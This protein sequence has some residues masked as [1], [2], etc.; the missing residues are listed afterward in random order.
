MDKKIAGLLG[1]VAAVG[2][3]ASAQAAPAPVPL[4]SDPLQVN[5]YSDLLE[6]IPNAVAVLKVLD[7]RAPASAEGNVQLAQFYHH[8]HHHHH[9]NH[10]RR[11]PR[12]GIVIG[13]HHHHH[14][15]YHH[16][17]HHFYHHHHHHHHDRY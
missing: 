2:A 4:A 8:H 15:F 16:H 9:H 7:E 3:L 1:A 5:S 17:H 12:I 13:R 10:W 11:G 14:H 6:P